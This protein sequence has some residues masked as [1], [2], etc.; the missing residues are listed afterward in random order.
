MR[1][2]YKQAQ[3]RRWCI[4]TAPAPRGPGPPPLPPTP[5]PTPYR[6]APPPP[7]ALRILHPASAPMPATRV[8]LWFYYV[9][10]LPGGLA[11]YTIAAASGCVSLSGS[12]SPGA[13]TALTQAEMNG[14]DGVRP[15]L[16]GRWEAVILDC[17]SVSWSIGAYASK[18][19]ASSAYKQVAQAWS[20]ANYQQ[21]R[22]QARREGSAAKG[23]GRRSIEI[24]RPEEDAKRAVRFEIMTLFTT[25]NRH[26]PLLCHRNSTK[27]GGRVR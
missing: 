17:N 16:G 15:Y 25:P 21:K 22:E 7:P 27:V 14:G 2:L 4:F 8:P 10:S 13:A 19:E 26:F 1:S 18:E 24:V 9:L 23:H 11:L 20:G 5:R 6:T 12:K 3:A